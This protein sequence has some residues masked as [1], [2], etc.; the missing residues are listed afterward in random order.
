MEFF[1]K[2]YTFFVASKFEKAD[3]ARFFMDE[4]A[5][6]GGSISYDWTPNQTLGPIMELSDNAEADRHGAATADCLIVILTTGLEAG[7]LVEMGVALNK[8]E[9]DFE[10][11]YDGN[12][13][14]IFV[15]DARKNKVDNIYFH[16]PSVL[17]L[18]TGEDHTGPKL[19]NDFESTVVALA[20]HDEG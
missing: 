11:Y 17:Y 4:I 14:D 2:G 5:R 20:C 12:Q 9:R 8:G 19:W 3:L 15:L 1:C 16:H 10:F 13:K 7:A 6:R 18:Q